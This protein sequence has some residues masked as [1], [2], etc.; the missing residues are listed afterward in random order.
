MD[1]RYF[2]GVVDGEPG[3]YGISFPDLP[4][5]V[6]AGD[7][8]QEVARNA[9]EA[10]QMHVDAMIDEGMPVPEPRALDQIEADSEVREV[11]R[12][13]VRAAIGQRAVRINVSIDEGLLGLIDREAVERGQTRSGFLAS[14]AREL[15]ERRVAAGKGKR[16]A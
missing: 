10:L 12:M 2:I 6:S 4:G 1:I 3:A 11:T 14:A 5:C 16:V 13:L 9:E 15:I 7:T 8:L